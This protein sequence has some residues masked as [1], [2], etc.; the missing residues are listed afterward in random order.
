[1]EAVDAMKKWLVLD[2]SEMYAEKKM[3]KQN[4]WNPFCLPGLAFV[5][6]ITKKAKSMSVSKFIFKISY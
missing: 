3:C 1:M 2:Y 5:Y 4:F 6:K